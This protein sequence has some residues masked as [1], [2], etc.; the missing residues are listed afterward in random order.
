MEAVFRGTSHRRLSQLHLQ[1]PCQRQYCLRRSG[2]VSLSICKR[3]SLGVPG[4]E[5]VSGSKTVQDARS[6]D[7]AIW[8]A[9]K[10]PGDA[11]LEYTGAALFWMIIYHADR[12]KESYFTY[13][14]DV[15]SPVD[16]DIHFRVCSNAHEIKYSKQ[17]EL[18]YRLPCM[19]LTIL[20]AR[21]WSR[22]LGDVHAPGID[23]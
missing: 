4:L 10:L 17:A 1:L 19:A 7:A 12:F 3:T 2:C 20:V 9:G 11:F 22:W 13:S 8:Q 15:E 14:T 5:I 23:L 16:H 21:D 18:Q 6:C